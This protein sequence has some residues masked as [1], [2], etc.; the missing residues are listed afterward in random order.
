MLVLHAEG[1]ATAGPIA[2]AARTIFRK[3]GWALTLARWRAVGW[4]RDGN[5]R[6]DGLLASSQAVSLMLKSSVQATVIGGAVLSAGLDALPSVCGELTRSAAI[7]D[8]WA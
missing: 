3:R 5:N 4:S 7:S 2:H 8:L 1:D 6:I